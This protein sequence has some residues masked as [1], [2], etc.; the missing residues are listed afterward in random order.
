[1]AHYVDDPG[2]T[3]EWAERLD[4]LIGK[5]RLSVEAIERIHDHYNVRSIGQRYLPSAVR[6]LAESPARNLPRYPGCREPGP[7]LRIAPR[8]TLRF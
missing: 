2:D 5:E 3:D 4:A 7:R 6:G 8:V 1:M